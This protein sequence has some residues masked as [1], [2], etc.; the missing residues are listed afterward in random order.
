MPFYQCH[1]CDSDMVQRQCH[2][3]FMHCQQ[4]A[5]AGV[6]LPGNDDSVY[7][8]LASTFAIRCSSDLFKKVIFNN[9]ALWTNGQGTGLPIHA[10]VYHH[11]SSDG[12]KASTNTTG[13]N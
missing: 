2:V 9:K 5:A 6:P 11:S 10:C 12:N 1:T 8:R 13:D 3:I 4:Y 7:T